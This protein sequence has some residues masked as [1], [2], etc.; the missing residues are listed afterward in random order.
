M[1]R[2]AELIEE[3]WERMVSFYGYPKAHWRQLRTTNVMEWLFAAL[4]LRTDAAKRFK[5]GANATAVI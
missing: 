4:R 3:D 1:E 5:K 2:A